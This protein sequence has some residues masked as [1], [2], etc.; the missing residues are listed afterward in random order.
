MSFT[1]N[2]LRKH[3]TSPWLCYC[4]G[5]IGR[6]HVWIFLY[7]QIYFEFRSL[8]LINFSPKFVDNK[9]RYG[10]FLYLIYFSECF[11]DEFYKKLAKKTRNFSMT[12]LLFRTVMQSCRF[13]GAECLSYQVSF[14]WL[15]ILLRPFSEWILH[16]FKNLSH[17]ASWQFTLGA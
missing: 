15:E 17:T 11:L 12:L 8:T 16:P 3:V 4:F 2:W 5:Q 13:H 10:A 9:I 7:R 6:A 1:K 14:P